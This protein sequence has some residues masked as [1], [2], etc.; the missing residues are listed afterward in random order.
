MT[1][2]SMMMVKIISIFFFVKSSIIYFIDNAGAS[3]EIM[4]NKYDWQSK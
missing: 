2:K 3:N 1:N 4:S